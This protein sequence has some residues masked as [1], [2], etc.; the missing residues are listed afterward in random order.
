MREHERNLTEGLHRLCKDVKNRDSM[1]EIGSWGGESA[2]IFAQYFKSVIC[3]DP[4]EDPDVFAAFLERTM[5]HKNIRYMIMTSAEAADSFPSESLS[6]V[7]IDGNHKYEAVRND[8][9][10]WLPKIMVGGRISGHDYKE[11]SH[12]DVVRAVNSVFG[13]PTKVYKDNSWLI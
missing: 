1:V 4:W 7:Y 5:P 3:V 8:L 12:M 6:F 13:K 9:R 2:V 10:L 11:K